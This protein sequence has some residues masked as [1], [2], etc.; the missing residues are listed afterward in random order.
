MPDII[1]AIETP[2][3]SV[4]FSNGVREDGLAFLAE[5]R[6]QGKHVICWGRPADPL[7]ML[8]PEQ[9]YQLRLWAHFPNA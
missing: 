3:W 4:M 7:L 6:T 5:H 9:S 1:A 8:L 2:A